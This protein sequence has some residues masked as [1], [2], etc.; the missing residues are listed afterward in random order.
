MGVPVVAG[1]LSGRKGVV[2]KLGMDAHWRGAIV[3]CNG[4]REAGMDVVYLGHTTPADLVAAVRRERPDLV[5]LSSLTGNHLQECRRLMSALDAEGLGDLRVVVGG[6]IPAEDRDTLLALGVDG[7]FG[8]GSRL[9]VI[10]DDVAALL[11]H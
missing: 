1:V 5:G 3:V 7:I 4:L 11:D 6:T 10:V 9:D 2:A 8:T